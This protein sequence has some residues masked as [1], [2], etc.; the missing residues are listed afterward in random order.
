MGLFSRKSDAEL[1]A[2][3]Y[4]GRESAS[5]KQARK[6][7]EKQAR[8]SAQNPAAADPMSIYEAVRSTPES[9]QRRNRVTR[10]LS[11]RKAAS[12]IPDQ[13]NR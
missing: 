2:T 7:A 9:Q 4:A 12:E 13:W 10:A 1:A 6:N 11:A 8:Q 5:Q 3:K